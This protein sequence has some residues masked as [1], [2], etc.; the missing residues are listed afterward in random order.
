[1]NSVTNSFENPKGQ[2][3]PVLTIGIFDG[4]HL[5]HRALFD[6]VTEMAKKNH[7]TSMV[8]TFDPHPQQVLR[9]KKDFRLLTPM[10]DRIKHIIDSGVNQVIRE[11]F[12]MELASFSAKEFIKE[13][14]VKRL[15][16]R[17]LW[18]G[19]GFQFGKD[20]VGTI[21]L[22][23]K[24]G[25]QN[26]FSVHVLKPVKIGGEII[27]STRIRL[28]IESGEIEIAQALLGRPYSIQGPISNGR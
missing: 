6:T 23:K 17:A 10:D 18:V 28:A 25:E 20:R 9:P 21:D 22:L 8:L 12:T 15:E 13:I 16:I 19:P 14:L 5:G 11:P 1:M 7:G 4:V 26:E 2:S 27:S 24:L 3:W